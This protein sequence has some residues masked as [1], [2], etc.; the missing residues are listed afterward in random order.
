MYCRE[1][2]E[3]MVA[4]AI[5]CFGYT[6]RISKDDGLKWALAGRLRVTI[7]HLKTGVVFLR[8][9]FGAMGFKVLK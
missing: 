9:L 3:A 8:P 4:V 2:K 7:V 6:R 5:G 1:V